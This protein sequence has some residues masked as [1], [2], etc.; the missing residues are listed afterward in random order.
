MDSTQLA[1]EF[2][3]LALP[4]F[5]EALALDLGLWLVEA[6]RAEA[7]PVV[8]DIRTPNRGLFHAALP[9]SAPLNDLWV[10]RKAATA[11]LFH[12]P[13]LL[14][15]TRHREKGEALAKHGLTTQTHA[16]HGGAVPVVVA[17]SGVVACVTVSGL[18]QVD[19]HRLAVQGL[20]ALAARLAAGV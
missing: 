10:A 7:A 20:Q 13:S 11:L 19:D 2:A 16:D 15:G 18:P 3:T 8:I 6:A 1:A 12:E 5:D 17:G 14:V 9:G 4:C